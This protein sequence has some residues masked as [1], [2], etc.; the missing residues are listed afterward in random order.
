MIKLLLPKIKLQEVKIK[1]KSWNLYILG[2]LKPLKI[3]NALFRLLRNIMKKPKE[4]CF[5]KDRS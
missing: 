5:I 2:I 1:I 3:K 4:H